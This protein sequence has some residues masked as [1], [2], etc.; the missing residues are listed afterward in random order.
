MNWFAIQTLTKREHVAA[1]NLTSQ[2]IETL[3]PRI[4]THRF[5]G[6]RHRATTEALFPGYI[7]AYCDPVEHF[8][9]IKRAI[10][11]R[12]WIDFAGQYPMVEVEIIEEIISNTVDGLVKLKKREREKFEFGE[13]APGEDVKIIAGPF[14]GLIGKLDAT[15]KGGERVAVLL[16]VMGGERRIEFDRTAVTNLIFA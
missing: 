9:K 11:V 1:D 6:Y 10:G 7:F 3:S 14:S 4:A 12:R 16:T 13:L 8:Y 5:D 15:M 2:E